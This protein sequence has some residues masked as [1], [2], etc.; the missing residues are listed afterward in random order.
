MYTNA[1]QFRRK[2]PEF[3][4]RINKEQPMIIGIT[5]VKPKNS[6]DKLFPA[7]FSIDHIGD[8]DSPFCKNITTNIGRGILLYVHKQLQAKE[9]EMKTE[10]Q[11]AIFVE[12]NLNEH[13]KLL[14]GCIYRSE[15]GTEENKNSPVTG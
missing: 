3:T 7:E 10:F 11:E 6:I 2:F 5:E 12:M 9:V 14:V 8:Y 1:D 4:V 13:D 15:S